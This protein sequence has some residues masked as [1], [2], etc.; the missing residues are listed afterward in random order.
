MRDFKGRDPMSKAGREQ[1]QAIVDKLA[2]VFVADV[3]RNR[4]VTEAVVLDGFGKGG[5]F[6]GTD[7]VAA[8]LADRVATFEVTHAALVARTVRSGVRPFSVAVAGRA[9]SATLLA[10]ILESV[11]LD[12]AVRP[13]RSSLSSCLRGT[14]MSQRYNL[15]ARQVGA[16]VEIVSL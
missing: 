13:I 3:G 10:Q 6:V 11:G 9:N 5:T 8:G 1:H 16:G 2:G 4:G 15:H 12:R 7:A 14:D